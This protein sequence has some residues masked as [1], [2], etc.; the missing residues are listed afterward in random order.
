MIY[1]PEYK[2]Y[3][4]WGPRAEPPEAIAARYSRVPIA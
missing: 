3:A 4:S 2:I 1:A